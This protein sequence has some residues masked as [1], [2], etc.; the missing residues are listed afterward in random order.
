MLGGLPRCTLVSS[1]SSKMWNAGWLVFP[2]CP[3][4]MK[5]VCFLASGISLGAVVVQWLRHLAIVRKVPG[6][7]ITILQV[8]P[9]RKAL[10][11]KL[12]KCITIRSLWL[13]AFVKCY[14]YK[15]LVISRMYPALCPKFPAVKVV[16]GPSPPTTLPRISA[17]HDGFMFSWEALSLLYWYLLFYQM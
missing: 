6:S 12:L 3:Y 1:C 8:G 5:R 2:N 14:E 11:P 13:R 16:G 9:L 15:R 7:N 10:S 17:I 4:F